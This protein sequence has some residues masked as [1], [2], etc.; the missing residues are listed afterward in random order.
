[1]NRKVHVACNF[2]RLLRTSRFFS[3]TD[4]LLRRTSQGHGR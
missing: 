2:N 1:V 3:L 4:F